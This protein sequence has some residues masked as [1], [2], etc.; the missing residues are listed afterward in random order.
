MHYV[1]ILVWEAYKACHIT[2][3]YIIVNTVFFRFKENQG[4]STGTDFSRNT[5]VLPG[6]SCRVQ[7]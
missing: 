4:S 2:R 6:V 3:R 1:N 5:L 7:P